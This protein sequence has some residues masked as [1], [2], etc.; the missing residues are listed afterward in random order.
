MTK[1]CAAPDVK[2]VVNSL[3]HHNIF[4]IG[5]SMY[6]PAY[7]FLLYWLYYLNNLPR[8]LSLRLLLFNKSLK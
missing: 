3:V 6:N 8:S 1:V 2:L 5:E 7:S 4:R